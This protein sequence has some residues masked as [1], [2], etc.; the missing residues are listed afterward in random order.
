MS[1]T[2]DAEPIAAL[3]RDAGVVRTQGRSFPVDV[4][5]MD[6]SARDAGNFAALTRAVVA[7]VRKGVEQPGD[8]LVF[9][10]GAAEI[11]RAQGAIQDAQIEA[12]L[13]VLPLFG[14]LAQA[15]QDRALRPSEDPRRRKVVLATNIAET[16]LTIEGVRT[17]VDCGLERRSRFDPVSGMNRLETRRISRA[18]A[19]QRAG[20]AGRLGPGRCLRLW[21]EGSQRSLEAHAPAEILE[22]DLAPLALDL[23]GW[24]VAQATQLAW[25]DAPPSA[26]LAQANDLLSR[27]GALDASG[28]ITP[29]GRAMLE[30]R[31]HP[32]LAH[33]M[34]RSRALDLETLAC[35][36]AALLAERDI[37][38]SRPGE[39]QSDLRV[40][41]EA[42]RRPTGDVDRA[43]VERVRRS[44]AQYR[45]LLGAGD[46]SRGD[47]DQMGVLLAFA[48]PDRIARRR[49]GDERAEGRR[50]L[51]AQQRP[52]CT[53]RWST[54]ARA[55]GV[56]GDSRS[57]C[58]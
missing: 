31:L 32:R 47:S 17:V 57:G 9:L 1:A 54:G 51:S 39:R 14:D 8:M 15:E 42:L 28:R 2:L 20:R 33:M 53:L 56:S 45:R 43:A 50:S 48:Y 49:K 40:R 44:S 3:L 34:L 41:L 12:G 29:H 10:P 7:A 6:F 23:A 5:Y 46:D 52:R 16:S 24:N 36:V 58:R 26:P 35:D 38:R 21:S 27:L 18:S 55:L 37:L 25:L 22:T 13:Q 11:R 19:E 4:E 30:L